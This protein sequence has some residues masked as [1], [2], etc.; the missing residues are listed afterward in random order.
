MG[1]DKEVVYHNVSFSSGKSR[2]DS[3]VRKA[4]TFPQDGGTR[5]PNW[6]FQRRTEAA[7]LPS[8]LQ[9]LPDRAG[10]LRIA[11][12][13]VLPV[14]VPFLPLEEHQPG[15]VGREEERLVSAPPP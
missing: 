15:V 7:V 5:P 13:G 12:Y 1:M 14:R 6:S 3:L 9:D 2:I 10:F 4:E 11:G 8:Q